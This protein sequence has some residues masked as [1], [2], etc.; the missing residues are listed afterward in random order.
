MR[1][2]MAW[3]LGLLGLFGLLTFLSFDIQKGQGSFS[4]H[5][6]LPDA[7]IVWE[8][9]PNGFQH[10]VNLLRW[11]FGIGILALICLRQSVRLGRSQRSEPSNSADAVKP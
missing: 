10:E 1:R 2:V 8:D 7:W 4:F 3:V 9:R 11:S 6:G 5:M